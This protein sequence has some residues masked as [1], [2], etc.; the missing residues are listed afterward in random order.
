MILYII[1]FFLH[2]IFL[3]IPSLIYVGNSEGSVAA[4]VDG[5]LFSGTL[6]WRLSTGMFVW[7]CTLFIIIIII[8]F[9]FK[10]PKIKQPVMKTKKKRK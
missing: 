4:M 8:M 5:F 1:F 2:A 7:L 9:T 6:I 10:T 3:L